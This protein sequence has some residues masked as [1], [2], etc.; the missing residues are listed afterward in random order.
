[1][2]MKTKNI[3]AIALLPALTMLTAACSGDD[4]QQMD[5]RVPIT[6]SVASMDINAFTTRSAADIDLNHS[7]IESGQTVRVRVSNTNANSWTDYNFST[8]EGGTMTISGTAPYYPLDNTNVDIVAYY[9]SFAGTTFSIRSDQSTNDGYM[10]SDLLFASVANQEKTSTA[11]PLVFNH[12]MAKVV[13]TARAGMGVTNIQSI[14]LHKVLPDVPFNQQTGEIS[15]ATGN[16]TNVIMAK[17]ETATTVSGAALIPAQ[18]IEGDLLTIETNLGT[19]TYNVNSKTFAAGKIYNL[20][21][22]VNR[23]AV[24]ATTTVNGWTDTEG[25]V[26]KNDDQF[27][28][29]IIR[30]SNGSYSMTMVFVEGGPFTTLGGKNVTGTVSDFYIGQTEVTNGFW[31][32][33]YG[34][35]PSGQTKDSATYPLACASWD[36]AVAFAAALNTRF[37]NELDGMTFRLSSDVQWEYAARGGTAHET[38]TYAGSSNWQNVAAFKGNT[39]GS[40]TLPVATYYANSLGIYDMSGNLWEWMLDWYSDIAEGASLGKDYV[41]TSG[42]NHLIRGASFYEGTDRNPQYLPI[43]VRISYNIAQNNIGFRLVLQ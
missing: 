28:T 42:T 11:V 29:F 43:N 22:T 13:V 25:V 24:G 40:T 17:E 6:L 41:C 27:R 38:Y 9:P 8:G 14:T 23:A 1:M 16:I 10:A 15:S 30:D 19:A 12:K 3:L 18:T 35:V 33:M 21:I 2:P 32:T 4:E 36:Q 37:E 34:S 7:Y 20:E 39:G 26:I 31:W 5:G